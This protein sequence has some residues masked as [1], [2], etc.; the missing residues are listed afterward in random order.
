MTKNDEIK[1]PADRPSGLRFV[2]PKHWPDDDVAAAVEFLKRDIPTAW[3]E[4]EE[5]E[6][7]TGSIRGSEAALFQFGALSNLHPECGPNEI[8][9]LAWQVRLARRAALGLEI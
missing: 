1:T 3:A 4:L 9:D 2:E 5:L 7:T 6:R 8:S